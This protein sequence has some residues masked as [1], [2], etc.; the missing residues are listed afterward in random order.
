MGITASAIDAFRTSQPRRLNSDLG[1]TLANQ[2][3]AYMQMRQMRRDGADRMNYEYA[4]LL[5]TGLTL[6][7]HE[8]RAR[9]SQAEAKAGGP[10][11]YSRQIDDRIASAK[12]RLAAYP[13]AL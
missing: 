10:A 13:G 3:L 7:E 12:A 2:Q 1:M 11:A 9:V 4:F 8:T 5:A 6:Q